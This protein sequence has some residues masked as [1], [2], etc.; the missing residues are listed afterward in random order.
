M[1]FIKNKEI[2]SSRMQ[3]G[4][5]LWAGQSGDWVCD[6]DLHNRVGIR[7]WCFPLLGRFVKQKL[8]F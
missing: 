8:I 7:G 5:A 3:A 2:F 1:L 4:R 6:D